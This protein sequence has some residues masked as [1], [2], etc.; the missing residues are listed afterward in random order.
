MTTAI[1]ES[2]VEPV[3]PKRPWTL[4]LVVC[5]VFVFYG[6][7]YVSAVGLL[8][9]RDQRL[10][11]TE[12]GFAPGWPGWDAMWKA[13]KG[14]PPP[15]GWGMFEPMH[16]LIWWEAIGRAEAA[17]IGPFLLVGAWGIW[18]GRT[19]GRKCLYVYLFA[20]VADKA[21]YIAMLGEDGLGCLVLALMVAVLVDL[22]LRKGSWAA[23]I[24]QR[25]LKC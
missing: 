5:L 21:S 13:A 19:W 20:W 6:I 16:S 10:L 4:T 17:L 25:P 15:E 1:K 12:M 3:K 22:V 9:T 14:V 8:C 7:F 18:R 24:E 2:L 11:F 23:W